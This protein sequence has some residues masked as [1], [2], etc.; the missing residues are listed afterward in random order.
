MKR[1]RSRR[2]RK[3]EMGIRGEG[4]KKRKTRRE[5]KRGKIVSKRLKVVVREGRMNRRSRRNRKR[6]G[7]E[8]RE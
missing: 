7:V 5:N 6:D 8:V 2:N 4:M 3:R 1:R